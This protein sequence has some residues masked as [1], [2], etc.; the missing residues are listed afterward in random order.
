MPGLD[1]SGP[2]GK[3]PLTGRGR[4][5][6]VNDLGRIFKNAPHGVKLMTFIIPAVTTAIL[7]ARNP[8]GITRRLYSAVKNK[9]VSSSR[10]QISKT[11]VN[12]IDEKSK[13]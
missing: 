7:D 13:K 3:G 4:G 6:C 1:G 10:K 2:Q 5:L 11:Q 9:L 8:D 12:Y